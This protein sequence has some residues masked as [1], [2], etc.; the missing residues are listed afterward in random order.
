MRIP[1]SRTWRYGL[2]GRCALAAGLAAGPAL[3][4]PPFRTDDPETVDYQHFEI[5]PSLQGTKA[6]GGWAA[7]LPAVEANYGALPNL[8]PNVAISQGFV[9]PAGGRTGAALGNLELAV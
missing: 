8:Q 4:G 7:A 1:I 5:I 6:A 9:A 2:L 3:A